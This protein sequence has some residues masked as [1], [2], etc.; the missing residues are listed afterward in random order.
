MG[1]LQVLIHLIGDGHL[2]MCKGA[3]GLLISST[4]FWLNVIKK[5]SKG[6]AAE[7]AHLPCK[8][9]LASIRFVS[10]TNTQQSLNIKIPQLL[11]ETLILTVFFFLINLKCSFVIKLTTFIS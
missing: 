1:F 9:T 8:N 10:A 5:Q 7:L 11:N 4:H 6:S 3:K 2:C